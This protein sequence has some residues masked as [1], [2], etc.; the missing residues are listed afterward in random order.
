MKECYGGDDDSSYIYMQASCKLT[1][2]EVQSN[3]KFALLIGCFIICLSVGFSL[4][5]RRQE[6]LS[7]LIKLSYER[8]TISAADFTVRL[9]L[10]PD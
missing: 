6:K 3:K 5:M 10:H 2:Q 9:I 4:F 7:C 8:I 1:D